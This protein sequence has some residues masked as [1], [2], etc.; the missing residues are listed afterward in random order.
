MLAGE[1]LVADV[2]DQLESLIRQ[3]ATGVVC[4]G[5]GALE[6]GISGDHFARD[7]ILPDAE[8]LERALRPRPPKLVCRHFDGAEAF[9]FRANVFHVA[10]AGG[11]AM[12]DD[13]HP[14]SA[15]IFLVSAIA[16]AGL[17]PFGQ[18]LVQFMIVW[19]R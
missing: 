5:S 10:L 1:D 2:S 17:S 19:Q 3:S 18:L 4:R 8:V 16:C 7:Q 13:G 9:S 6:D 11:R 15:I 12:V 14:R